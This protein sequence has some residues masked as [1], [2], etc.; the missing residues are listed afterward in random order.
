MI[1]VLT[2][3]DGLGL[4]IQGM[5][6]AKDSLLPTMLPVLGT[7]I[8]AFIYTR[9]RPDPRIA[10]LCHMISAS[11]AFTAV[12]MVLSYLSV[13]LKQPLIDPELIS[14]DRM[15]GFDWRQMYGAIAST[16]WLHKTLKLI[17]LSLV[18]QMIVLQ[19]ILNFKGQITRGWE[20][21]WLFFTICLG[22]I[23]A[24]ALWPAAGAF[25]AFHIDNGEPYVREFASLRN[26]T[27]KIIGGHGGV[28]GV[29]QFP[30]LHT[31]LA[32][33]Y[34]Y[35]TRGIRILFPVFLILNLLVVLAT[36][37]IGGHHLSDVLAG[38]ALALLV[39]GLSRWPVLRK[40]L[41]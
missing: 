22:C 27:L 4:G 12:S 36:P 19:V 6:L 18:P 11:L 28:Q 41:A 10:S 2:A 13:T 30:S 5:E 17:Y 21:Q 14:A 16:P 15:T 29:I 25:G 7:G 34:I 8:L 31:A 32:I 20:L 33:L 40:Q 39:I 37:T 38:A 9:Y 23:L 1:A 3:L 26:G 24:S 35:A